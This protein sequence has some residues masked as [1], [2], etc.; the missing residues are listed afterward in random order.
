[1]PN[2][3]PVK[4]ALDCFKWL[5]KD[6][7]LLESTL[8]FE[9]YGSSLLLVSTLTWYQRRFHNSTIKS[10]SLKRFSAIRLGNYPKYIQ[11][12][13]SSKVSSISL[14]EGSKNRW[15][16]PGE[17]ISFLLIYTSPL[18]M[19]QRSRGSFL[20]V[21]CTHYQLPLGI[22]ISYKNLL[23]AKWSQLL[24]LDTIFNSGDKWY[25]SYHQY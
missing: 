23:I 2:C 16:H 19:L 15:E 9:Y 8:V 5:F 14:D 20:H 6:R 17:S 1:M 11:R 18:V 21:F 13:C 24:I 10:Y 22:W 3:H 12:N 25:D 7:G 4:E